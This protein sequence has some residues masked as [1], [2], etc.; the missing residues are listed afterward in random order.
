MESG[1]LKELHIPK[2]NLKAVKR[3]TKEKK[4]KL[5][6]GYEHPLCA[7]RESNAPLFSV[8]KQSFPNRKI[9]SLSLSL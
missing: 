1:S 8:H 9:L 5:L 4:E 6:I 3:I 7:M 2:R